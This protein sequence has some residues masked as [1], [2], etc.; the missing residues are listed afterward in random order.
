MD[1]FVGFLIG[2]ALAL[3]AFI[4]FDK[5]TEAELA[6]LKGKALFIQSLAENS[7]ARVKALEAAAEQA[8]KAL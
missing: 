5:Q 8:K 3:L 2:A 1:F 6:V 7:I 4:F